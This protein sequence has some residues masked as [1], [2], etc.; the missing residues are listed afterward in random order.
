ME[1]ENMVKVE[2]DNQEVAEESDEKVER[3]SE[4]R[5]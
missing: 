5:K 4:I 3:E 1:S 2:R